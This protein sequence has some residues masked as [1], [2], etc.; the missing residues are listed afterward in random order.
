MLFTI[1]SQSVF[2]LVKLLVKPSH[3]ADGMQLQPLIKLMSKNNISFAISCAHIIP[4]HIF[5]SVPCVV[6]KSMTLS[7]S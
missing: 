1:L 3:A 7:G 5:T 6:Y 4:F 2:I